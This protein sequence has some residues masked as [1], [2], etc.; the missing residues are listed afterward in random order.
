MI[1]QH[2]KTPAPRP[3]PSLPIKMSR[4]KRFANTRLLVYFI[5]GDAV[6]CTVTFDGNGPYTVRINRVISALAEKI[7]T[8]VSR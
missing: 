5:G 2:V 3:P 1:A 8:V 4:S 7:K 6:K